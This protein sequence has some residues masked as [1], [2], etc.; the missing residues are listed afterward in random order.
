MNSQELIKKAFE[1]YNENNVVRLPDIIPVHGFY[2]RFEKKMNRLIK[3]QNTNN[4]R[5]W[6]KTCTKWLATAAVI[7]ISLFT[8]NHISATVFNYNIWEAIVGSKGQQVQVEF[9]KSKDGS[10]QNS[11]PSK[12]LKL[13][14]MPKTYGLT[15]SRISEDFSVYICEMYDFYKSDNIN[16]T[17]TYTEML[18]DEGLK[19]IGKDGEKSEGIV[20]QWKVNYV[21][22]QDSIVAYFLDNKYCHTIVVQGANA[23]KEFVNTLIEGMGER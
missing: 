22:N 19:A 12:H 9:E 10:G 7:A 17:V 6:A 20:G 15:D 18:I 14:M 23:D 21:Q 16:G 2:N 8:V 3:T 5:G 4:R 13:D 11:V 1:Q